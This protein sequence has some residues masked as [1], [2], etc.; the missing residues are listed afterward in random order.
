LGTF[1]PFCPVGSAVTA[2]EIRQPAQ[3]VPALLEQ[4]EYALELVRDQEQAEQLWRNLAAIGEAA[5]L[6]RLHGDVQLHAGRLRL[7]AERR[8]GEL[9]GPAV[10]TGVPVTAGHRF[11][12]ADKKARERA[13]DVAAVEASIFTKYLARTT[14]PEKL[15]RARLL[16]LQREH[17]AEQQRQEPLPAVNAATVRHGDLRDTLNDLV[18]TVDAIVTDPPYG[19]AHLDEYD[20]LGELAERLLTPRGLLVVMVGQTHLPRYLERLGR[21]L[22]YRWTAAFLTA[23]PATRVHQAK[24]GTFWKP[25]LM[26][27]RGGE[28]R[29]I[30]QDVFRS[31]GPQKDLAGQVDGWGQ[32]ISGMTDILERVTLPGE[33]V[34]DPFCGAGTTGAACHALGRRFV[35]CDIDADAVAVARRRLDG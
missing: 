9:L 19:A 5:R 8:W 27:D 29:F 10:N 33:L 2:L 28:R 6:A 35:G 14:D 32:S 23:G 34:V 3:Q 13:R 12:D 20:A 25:L 24:V 18:G 16:R 22:D 17:E 21:H 11:T 31:G 15:R 26:F 30:V 4:A 1:K 7:R